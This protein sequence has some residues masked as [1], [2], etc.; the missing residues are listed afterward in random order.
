MVVG[1]SILHPVHIVIRKLTYSYVVQIR[2]RNVDQMRIYLSYADRGQGRRI[3]KRT[4]SYLVKSSIRKGIWIFCAEQDQETNLDIL[5]R[6]GSVKE[7]G[8]FVESRIRKRTWIFCA[9]QNQD[10]NLDILCRAE[11]GSEP[12]C[13][14]QS[15]IRK[16][17]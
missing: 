16:L 13:F 12:A 3:G 15:R 9:E 4:Y 11:S 8:Y 5:C 2:A 17:I 14:V 1:N 7:S 10:M 6:A